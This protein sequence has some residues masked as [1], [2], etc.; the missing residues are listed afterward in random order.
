MTTEKI[1]LTYPAAPKG[2][3]VD[4]YHGVSVAD[5]YRWLEDADSTETRQWIAGENA[6]T[7]K[8]LHAL[9]ARRTLR[10]RLEA[11]WD[12]EKFGVPFQRSGR[13][14]YSKNNGLQNQSVLYV[15][16]GLKGEPK[17]LLDPNGLSKDGTVALDS[18]SISEDGRLMAYSLAASGSDWVEWRV[19]DVQ[20]A[21]D[22]PDHLKWSKFSGAAW[23]HD[24]SGFYYNR[25][26]EPQAGKQ[27]E[28]ANYNQQVCFHRTGTPQ[29]DDTLVYERPDHKEWMFGAE[30]TDDG[31]YLVLEVAKDTGARNGVFVKDL[32]K[33]DSG[34]TELLKD[35]DAQYSL[36]GNE[37]SLFWFK[38]NL[39]APRGRLIAIDIDHPEKD[40]WRSLIPEVRETLEGVSLVHDSFVAT[41]LKDAHSVVRH[42]DLAGKYLG[43]I[44]LPGLGAAGGFGGRREDAETFYSYSGFT[45]PPTVYRYDFVSGKTEVFREPKVDFNPD[46]F[47][48][49]QVFYTSKDGTRVPMF[50]AYKNGL[51]RDGTAPTVLY[52][53]GGFNASMTPFFSVTN[54]VWME[55]GGIFAMPGI[56]GGGEYGEE[57]HLAGTVARKQNVFDD[58]IAAAEY[59][60]REKYTSTPKLA[61]S[62]GSN[63]GLLV[64]A[65]LVQRPDLFGAAMPAVGVM[66]MLR[67]QK[68]TIGWAWA[69]DYG[70]SDDPDQFKALYAYSPLQNIKPGVKY[71]ATIITTGDHDDRVVPA[72]SFK[73]AATLQA[74]QAGDAPI[75]IRIDTKAGHGGGKP[76]AKVLDEIADK[77]AFL[78]QVLGVDASAL[79]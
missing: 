5:P 18:F 17:V 53:Y 70:T 45:A 6:V 16:D 77:Y 46:E 64:G 22:L 2:G 57:W 66:D 48:S 30:V 33:P 15:M 71:P 39:D 20:T 69:S 54:L 60:I 38:T 9:P 27:L 32:M 68:F 51:K 73:F 11:L 25:Y 1:S 10:K 26:A 21:E 72:H 52:G 23:A 28:Q 41:Y 76:T 47:T 4:D 35:F 7:E 63:G 55:M 61:I 79:R 43:A 75:L 31:K 29:A 13:Y 50:I 67:Y 62:G 24:G 42:F 56:R 3:V 34:F 40:R 49:E 19:R 74:A 36:V 78:C 58:F 65:C 14:F 8:Y 44:D 12:Y 59:L 37:G